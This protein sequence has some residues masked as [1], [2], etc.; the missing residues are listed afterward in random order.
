[1]L[2]T[3][4]KSL[5]ESPGTILRVFALSNSLCGEEIKKHWSF[6]GGLLL[7]EAQE[8]LS[9]GKVKEKAQIAPITEMMSPK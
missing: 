1:M 5:K 8:F 3:S 7:E 4:A 2:L 9:L 6:V